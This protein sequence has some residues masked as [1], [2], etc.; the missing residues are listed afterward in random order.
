MKL[1]YNYKNRKQDHLE[2]LLQSFLLPPTNPPMKICTNQKGSK[3][4][5]DCTLE[6]WNGW[7]LGFGWEGGNCLG[8]MGKRGAAA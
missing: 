4:E 5:S 3:G 7:G 1:Q 6:E 2:L 8:R